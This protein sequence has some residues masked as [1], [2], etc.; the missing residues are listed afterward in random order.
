M[1]ADACEQLA[2]ACDRLAART[3]SPSRFLRDLGH[4]VAGVR[5]G[6]FWFLD[7][8]SGGSNRVRGRGF[9]RHVDDGTEGQARHFAGIVSVAAR[10]GPRVT[11]WLSIHVG[12]D[13]PDSADGRLTDLA[14]DF[15]RSVRSGE[16]PLSDAGDWVRSRLCAGAPSVRRR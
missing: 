6:P 12:R 3:P 15:V 8:G 13:A 7:A 16:L 4:E 10:V 14:V 5:R 11:R 2:A 9:R 1:T